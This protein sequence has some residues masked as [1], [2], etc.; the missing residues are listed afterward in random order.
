MLTH[1]GGTAMDIC[2]SALS[3]KLNTKLTSRRISAQIFNVV[4]DTRHWYLHNSKDIRSK[5]LNTVKQNKFL[6]TM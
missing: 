5:C 1:Q 3:K 4:L 2:Q 6:R